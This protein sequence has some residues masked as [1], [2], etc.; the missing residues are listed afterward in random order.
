MNLGR[1]PGF[2]TTH[3]SFAPRKSEN[4][5][6]TWDYLGGVR[7][8]WDDCLCPENLSNPSW[9]RFTSLSARCRS[10]RWSYQK[11]ADVLTREK[12]LAVSANAIFS[13]V[14]VRAKRRSLYALPP[15][16]SPPSF[17][18]ATTQGA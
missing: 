3:P 17:P 10:K 12:G 1:H 7:I 5:Q 13:F 6:K 9:S 18:A 8:T 16:E 2:I 4:S 15:L 11:I 14:K